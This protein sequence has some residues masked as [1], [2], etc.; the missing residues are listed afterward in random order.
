MELYKIVTPG[1][2]LEISNDENRTLY[3]GLAGAGSIMNIIYPILAGLLVTV[4]GYM[5]V[6]ILTS[7]Y[8][9]TG[10]YFAKSIICVRFISKEPLQ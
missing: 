8:I 3:T 5:S 6:F 1:V 2:L 10:F 7:L 4:I 9:L